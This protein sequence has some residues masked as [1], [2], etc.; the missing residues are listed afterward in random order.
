MPSASPIGADIKTCDCLIGIDDL[1]GEP[2][3]GNT[4]FV[5]DLKG[6]SDGA[7]NVIPRY[8]DD[9]SGRVGKVR[10]SIWEEIKMI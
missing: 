7:V 5:V 4:F 10:E 6:R 2:V 8:V 3:R 1:H 9:T